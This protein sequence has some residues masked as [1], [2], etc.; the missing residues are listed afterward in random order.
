MVEP[1]ASFT[2]VAQTSARVGQAMMRA[3]GRLRA[4]SGGLVFLSG[5]LG[6]HGR[7]VAGSLAALSLNA[8]FL[9]VT[10]MGVLSDHGEV[11]E[12]SAAAGV[13]W[14]G[15][16]C[17][18]VSVKESPPAELGDQLAER[19]D[20]LLQ[21]SERTVV[22]FFRSNGVDP[23]SLE[24]LSELHHAEHVFGAGSAPNTEILSVSVDG[25]IQGGAAA[26]LVLAGVS[27]PKLA[28]SQA[29]RLL[30]PLLRITD[31]RGPM[32]LT[33]EGQ[34][35]LQ[36]LNAVGATLTSQALILA[37]LS[38]EGAE[39]P[40]SRRPPLLVR[41]IQGVDPSR[42]GLMISDE[43]RVGH[44]IAFAVRDGASARTDLQAALAE[45]AQET[46]GAAPRFGLYMNCAGRGS[47]L[48]GANDV[49]TR[50]LKARFS[51]VPF[52]GL[53]SSFEVAPY[54]RR[55]ALQLYSGVFALFTSPS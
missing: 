55:P 36:S 19:L 4:P 2:T 23:H 18:P 29:C 51:H 13:V 48:Y 1:A 26:A 8:P 6:T 42:G 31:V 15:G 3:A 20:P 9:V 28:S 44:R 40:E 54:L 22:T 14:S 50:L 16:S 53:M 32:I 24:P 17:I 11:E 52:A 37:V 41:T 5:R 27:P 49:D 10:G 46:A 25:D 7:E 43:V 30:S 12:Q 47:S 38:P 34:S 21:G 35:A 45:M 33:I 39:G